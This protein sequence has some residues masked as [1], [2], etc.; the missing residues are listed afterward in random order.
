MKQDRK[1]T[2]LKI[3]QGLIWQ[4]GYDAGQIRSEIYPDVAGSLKAWSAA[5]LRLFVYS[6]NSSWRR[7]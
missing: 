4:E 1:A 3:I 2:P 6:P 7:S 5:G